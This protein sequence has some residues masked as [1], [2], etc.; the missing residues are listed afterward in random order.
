MTQTKLEHIKWY[1][2]NYIDDKQ[3]RPEKAS[4]FLDILY[5]SHNNMPIRLWENFDAKRTVHILLCNMT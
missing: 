5:L 2:I 3:E 1:I 4:F